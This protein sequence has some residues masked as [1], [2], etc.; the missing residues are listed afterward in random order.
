MG[1]NAEDGVT[2]GKTALGGWRVKVPVRS[3]MGRQGHQEVTYTD[4][5]RVVVEETAP[6]V[7]VCYLVNTLGMELGKKL[8][9]LQVPPRDTVSGLLG[10]WCGPH[11]LISRSS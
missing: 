4:N 7:C 10:C 1:R 5:P 6:R 3:Q 2:V 9:F 11:C 8:E